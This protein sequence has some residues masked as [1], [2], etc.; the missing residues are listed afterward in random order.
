MPQCSLYS[1]ISLE[2]GG[3]STETILKYHPYFSQD[4]PCSIEP[5]LRKSGLC[6]SLCQREYI[7]SL[8]LN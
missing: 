4:W 7:N 6:F 8:T 1:Y 3:G 2:Q 5:M